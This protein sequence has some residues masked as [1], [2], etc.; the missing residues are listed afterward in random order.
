M[1]SYTCFPEKN[2]TP[3]D[4]DATFSSEKGSEGTVLTMFK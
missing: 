2:L 1:K 4:N 3:W